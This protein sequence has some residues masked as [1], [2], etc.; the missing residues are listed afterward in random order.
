MSDNTETTDPTLQT[1]PQPITRPIY[2]RHV[3]EAV[4]NQI[5]E[6]AIKSRLRLSAYLVRLMEHSQPFTPQ[7]LAKRHR[8]PQNGQP[9][10]A[11]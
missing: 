11:P 4:W 7:P 5:H 1:Q 2:V 9:T 3:P 10:P 8:Q 6:N